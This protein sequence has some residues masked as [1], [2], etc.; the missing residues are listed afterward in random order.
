M[1]AP[2]IAVTDLRRSFA[3][4]EVLRG[5][6]A[7]VRQG[8]V[9]AVVGVN[10][11]GKSTL[12]EILATLLLPTSGRARVA[13]CDVVH[14]AS[15]V[16]RLIGYCPS[17]PQSFYPRLTGRRNLAFFAALYGVDAHASERRIDWLLERVGLA[18]AAGIRVERY[19]DGMKARLSIA[20]AL[21]TDAPVLL[22]D[23][24]TKSLDPSARD[25]IRPLILGEGPSRAPRT[26][27]WVTHDL[28]EA[29]EMADRI[30]VLEDGR[31]RE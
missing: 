31:L 14:Q 26:I 8:E 29:G 27:V 2:T 16:R 23:E 18:E 1:T 30:G 13:G 4:R 21:L 24:P 10:G 3:G 6:S 12:I 19:S 5:V 28:K 20:R 11:S 15:D 9:F 7:D 17:N 22:L 25:M